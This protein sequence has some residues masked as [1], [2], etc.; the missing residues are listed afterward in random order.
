MWHMGIGPLFNYRNGTWRLGHTYTPRRGGRRPARSIPTSRE[1]GSHTIVP[2]QRC[3]QNKPRTKTTTQGC[4]ACQMAS[5]SESDELCSWLRAQGGAVH[6]SL[7]LVR[8]CPGGD[9][10]V[11][12]TAPIDKGDV[13]LR[14]PR[15]A[16]LTAA[17]LP[18][19]VR[20]APEFAL[21]PPLV[22]TALALLAEVWGGVGRCGRT[23]CRVSQGQ[24]SLARRG[25]RG[26]AFASARSDTRSIALGSP[27]RRK[28]A[29]RCAV[30]ARGVARSDSARTDATS[31]GGGRPAARRLCR[32]RRLALRLAPSVVRRRSLPLPDSTRAARALRGR[33][34]S[35]RSRRRTTRPSLGARPSS[36]RSPA[37]RSA[38]SSRAAPAAARPSASCGTFR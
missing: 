14:V 2:I 9:R 35:R 26:R 33:R 36:T 7:N 25:A 12:A 24:L 21:C 15:S 27:G 23:N 4:L 1:E 32:R 20:G 18:A 3:T 34:T 16:A 31:R 5:S 6:T 8:R 37:R 28:R 13:L 22:Q 38:T 11:F 17:A 30:R 10:G 29:R 19:V